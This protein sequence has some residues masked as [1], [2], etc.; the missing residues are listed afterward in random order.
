MSLTP[1]YIAK[2]HFGYTVQFPIF[3]KS[4]IN[5][6]YFSTLADAEKVKNALM[7]EKH[8][9]EKSEVWNNAVQTRKQGYG[10]KEAD[11]A[12]KQHI[13]NI[14]GVK[15]YTKKE[16][17]WKKSSSSLD[18]GPEEDVVDDGDL[19]SQPMTETS[20][21]ANAI[22]EIIPVLKKLN[23]HLDRKP[24]RDWMHSLVKG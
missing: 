3:E 13:S 8:A 1:Q 5:W 20:R 15:S 18:S 14:T 21:L 19:F 17:D 4:R 6:Q 11:A 10:Q 9:L 2:T 12:L 24:T 23:K 16:I 22:E 7:C